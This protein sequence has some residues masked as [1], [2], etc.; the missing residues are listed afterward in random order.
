MYSQVIF[1]FSG[2]HMEHGRMG[3]WFWNYILIPVTSMGISCSSKW[4]ITRNSCWHYKALWGVVT[5]D[6]I[7]FIEVNP[8][9][10]SMLFCWSNDLVWRSFVLLMT[11]LIWGKNQQY[12]LLL[13]PHIL[14]LHLVLLLHPQ[15]F[16][17][18]YQKQLVIF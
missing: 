13:H 11:R 8:K 14:L 4:R 6:F 17:Y 9:E 18:L 5:F 1:S 16:W 10:I 7:S 12:V 2:F 15:K 3:L